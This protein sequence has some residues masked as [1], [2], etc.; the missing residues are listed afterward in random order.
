MS[1][2]SAA[3][4]QVVVGLTIVLVSPFKHLDETFDLQERADLVL[5]GDGE[6]K[7]CGSTRIIS[8]WLDQRLRNSVPATHGAAHIE[9]SR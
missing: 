2:S 1:L 7:L 3:Q 8:D 9:P 5:A 4:R 6:R